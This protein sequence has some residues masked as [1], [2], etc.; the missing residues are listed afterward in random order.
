MLLANPSVS[1]KQRISLGPQ[2]VAT[3]FCQT[4]QKSINGCKTSN[5]FSVVG[6]EAWEAAHTVGW[7]GCWL[8]YN[9]GDFVAVSLDPLDRNRVAKK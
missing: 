4:I 8:I 6:C 9:F 7:L 1:R 5:V 2:K 3:L